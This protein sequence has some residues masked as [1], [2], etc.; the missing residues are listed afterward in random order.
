MTNDGNDYHSESI[1]KSIACFVSMEEPLVLD[2]PFKISLTKGIQKTQIQR[3][4][5]EPEYFAYILDSGS[6]K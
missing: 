2:S 6:K 1:M 5:K 3:I 4:S